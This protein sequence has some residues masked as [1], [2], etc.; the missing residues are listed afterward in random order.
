MAALHLSPASSACPWPVSWCWWLMNDDRIHR[1]NLVFPESTPAQLPIEPHSSIE[2]LG[3]WGL[4]RVTVTRSKPGSLRAVIRWMSLIKQSGPVPP[5]CAS[6][7]VRLGG[8]GPREAL[9]L[10]GTYLMH[11]S[12]RCV[13][14]IFPTLLVR[15]C[16]AACFLLPDN[17]SSRPP[18]LYDS[19]P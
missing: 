2:P 10:I 8:S 18:T 5:F 13:L 4:R 14:S 9:H 6:L 11:L 17:C 1:G 12:R 16:R 7:L 19:T 15:R 3:G